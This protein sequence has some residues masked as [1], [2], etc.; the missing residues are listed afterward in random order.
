VPEF[1]LLPGARGLDFDGGGRIQAD[2]RHRV[3]VDDST[4]AAIRG[5]A[6]MRRYDAI[7]EVVPGGSSASPGDYVHDCGFAP[8]PWQEACP[9]CGD[10][11][12]RSEVS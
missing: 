9:R 3:K 5:S 7:I 1:V 2:R 6:A 8:W 12:N 4:A 11:I 10:P